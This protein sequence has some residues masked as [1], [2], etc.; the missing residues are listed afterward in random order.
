MSIG[1]FAE[2]LGVSIS[3]LRRWEKV[4]KLIPKLRTAGFHRRYSYEQFLEYSKSEGV[5][6]EK[7]KDLAY[8]RVS[9]ADQREDLK[10]QQ[11]T[12]H[13]YCSKA[14][15]DYELISDLGSGMNYKKKGLKKLITLLLSGVVRR[16]VLTH[17]DRLLR[18][19]SE[20]IF[21]LA[22]FFETEMIMIHEEESLSDE[23]KLARDVLEIITVFSSRLYG[24][25]A[26]K[27]KN[28]KVDSSAND[29]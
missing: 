4:G 19:G 6:K 13:Q 27:N 15:F 17:K 28:K 5:S 25:R 29:K 20:I 26:H 12:L 11:N 3:T 23:V 16:I 9:S 21:Y 10:R 24:K 14:G 22:S 7:R 8:A 1:R 2:L 18:F